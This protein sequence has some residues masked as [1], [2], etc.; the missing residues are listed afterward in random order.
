MS[1]VLFWQLRWTIWAMAR[2]VGYRHYE[3]I[4]GSVVLCCHTN[5]LGHMIQ[6]LRI[7]EVFEAAA[8]HVSLVV[9]ADAA[10]IPA[11]HMRRLQAL[12]GAAPIVDLAHEV[13][14][15][16]NLGGAVANWRVVIDAMWKILGPAGRTIAEIIAESASNDRAFRAHHTLPSRVR[17]AHGGPHG[18]IARRAPPGD[19]RLAMGPSPAAGHQFRQR[20]VRRAAG[21]RVA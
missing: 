6:M 9:I 4:P 16:E 19:V 13:H 18:A 7:L 21:S 1:D 8:V 20:E 3:P 12:A 10:K 14:Y 17:L 11:D 5:G 2:V 15:D